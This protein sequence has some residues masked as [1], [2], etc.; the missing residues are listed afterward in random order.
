MRLETGADDPHLHPLCEPAATSSLMY[1]SKMCLLLNI[2]LFGRVREIF[3][4]ISI[5][6]VTF[7]S[8]AI[9]I[10]GSEFHLSQKLKF[11]Q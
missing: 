1:L 8:V 5:L 6:H 2:A 10:S 11:C 7:L 3:P 9:L 4:V